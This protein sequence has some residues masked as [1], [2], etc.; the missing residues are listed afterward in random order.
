MTL[1][2]TS[3]FATVYNNVFR[4]IM[5]HQDTEYLFTGGRASIKSSFISL[6]IVL[7]IRMNPSFNAVIV[8]K[9]KTSLRNSVFEQII[10][11]IKMLHCEH[12]FK[13]PQSTKEAMPIVYKKTGQ[14]IIFVGSDDP[15]KIK[16]LKVAVGYFAILWIEEKSEFTQ[17]DVTH[18]KA[19]ALR[20]G[21]V[22]YVFESY[23]PPSSP[24]NWCNQDSRQSKEG[25]FVLHTTYLDI[26]KEHPEWLGGAII[27]EIEFM[28]K[29]NPRAYENVYLGKATGT[30][31][32]IFENV[33]LR[34]ITKEE[35]NAMDFHYSGLD[36]GFYPDP[37][38]YNQFSYDMR[39]K[40]LYIYDELKLYKHGNYEASE[41]LKEHLHDFYLSIGFKEYDIPNFMQF[42][43][44]GDS[45]EPKSIADFRQYGWNMRGAIKGK[46]SLD[47]GMKWLQ[48]RAKIVIDPVRCPETADEFS[49]Y[50]YEIDRR[51]GEILTGFPDGQPDHAI[52]SLRY[53]TEEIWKQRGV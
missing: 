49:M 23:N 32:N 34:P 35:I 47:T 30:G 39:T 5:K 11:A 10:W 24:R 1:D 50:E 28:R 18:I 40:T 9:Y 37:L 3:L 36:F 41:K 21:E 19:S 45:A 12:L 52:A 51:T 46:G 4:R 14:K 27:N 22:F 42:R 33:E 26:I 25:R 20:G 29:N 44:T 8:R 38:L 53:G 15:E 7:L 48:T 43:I 6:C 13:I 2:S 16:G 31:T 17:T